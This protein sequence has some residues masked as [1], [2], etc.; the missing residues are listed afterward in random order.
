M[1][2]FD[3]LLP[4]AN[5]MLTMGIG[6]SLAVMGGALAL[7]IRH[8]IDWDHIAAITDIT[9]TTAARQHPDETW[10]TGEPGVMLTDESHHSLAAE[11]LRAGA[12][13]EAERTLA[14]VRPMAA[15]VGAG[16]G[17]GPFIGGK[18]GTGTA[19]LNGG[20]RRRWGLSTFAAEQRHALLLGTLYALGHGTVVTLLG[21]LAILAQAFL[22]DWIDPVME[23]VVGV[24]L[25][26]L[27]AYLFYS[28]YRFLRGGDEFHLRSRW[29]LIFAGVRNGFNWLHAHIRHEHHHRVE[30]AQQ[31]GVRTAYGV[32]LIHGIG[33]ETGTQVLVIATAVGAGSKAMSVVTLMA[34]VVGLLISN[35]FVTVMTTAGFVSAR[36]RQVIYAAAGLLAAVF[37]LTVGLVFIS[38][39]GISLPD[40]GHYFRWIGGPD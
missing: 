22:P 33:A 27:A 5:V 23:R 7:G 30:A 2:L 32:G 18:A 20:G 3:S 9:S 24:T 19:A 37:S 6:G 14:S 11:Q 39:A 16:V 29:M 21:L 38:G 13:S 28:L 15:T 4:P 35:S 40:L 10:L 31:Y 17:A 36:R 1:D 12:V 25:V 26:F 34:F 8:G